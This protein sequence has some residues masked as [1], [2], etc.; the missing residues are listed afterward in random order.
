MFIGG[1]E[2]EIAAIVWNNSSNVLFPIIPCEQ[3]K[4]KMSYDVI[5]WLLTDKT[6]SIA[7]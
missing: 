4:L 5:I 2:A 1:L 6:I 3:A 7:S